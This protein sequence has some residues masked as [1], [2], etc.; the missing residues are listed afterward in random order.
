MKRY[1]QPSPLPRKL[2]LS[3]LALTTLVALHI[4]P[5]ATPVTPRPA[6]DSLHADASPQGLLPWAMRLLEHQAYTW[7]KNTPIIIYQRPEQIM[8]DKSRSEKDSIDLGRLDLKIK[9]PEFHK[10]RNP[11][12]M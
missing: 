8:I 10:A 2:I 3:V 7:L 9:N 12:S 4:S 5:I 11:E 6:T 1:L